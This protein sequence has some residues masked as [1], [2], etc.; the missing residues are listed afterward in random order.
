MIWMMRIPDCDRLFVCD[1]WVVLNIWNFSLESL[2]VRDHCGDDH[3]SFETD[4]RWLFVEE[5]LNCALS[6]EI[7]QVCIQLLANTL[8]EFEFIGFV[9][10]RPIHL[11]LREQLRFVRLPKSNWKRRPLPSSQHWPHLIHYPSPIS[12]QV[13]LL[14]PFSVEL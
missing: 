3:Y 9:S 2:S 7:F 1:V 14:P 8:A 12:H 13:K 6:K 5:Q 11:H 4:L 10:T